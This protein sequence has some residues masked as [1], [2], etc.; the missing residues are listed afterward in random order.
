MTTPAKINDMAEHAAHAALDAFGK[1]QLPSALTAYSF[2]FQVEYDEA[3]GPMPPQFTGREFRAF[4]HDYC[5]W[6]RNLGVDTET[7]QAAAFR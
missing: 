5:R 7:A 3:D 1:D 4:R 6:L 2:V